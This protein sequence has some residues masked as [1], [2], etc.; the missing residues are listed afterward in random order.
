M[1]I[2]QGFI[3]SSTNNQ[4]TTLGREG[5]DYSAAILANLCNATKVVVWK[6]VP[7]I[8]NADPNRMSKV[9]KINHLSY[10]EAIEFTYYGAKVIHAKTI[11]PLKQK[12]I[13]LYVKSFIDTTTDGS[14]VDAYGPSVYDCPVYIYKDN[15]VLVSISPK[16]EDVLDSK[17]LLSVFDLI[18]NLRISINL[19]QMSASSFT[20]CI[21]STKNFYNDFIQKLNTKFNVRYNE[22]VELVTIRYYDEQSLELVKKDAKILIEQKTRKTAQIVK[23]ILT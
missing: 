17:I 16:N 20:F 8:M 18:H 4:T 1:Y 22:S 13:P 11:E 19:T 6:D 23:L 15:Q 7:G 12:L 5:S 21:D 9:V 2:T 10:S 14:L 3:A